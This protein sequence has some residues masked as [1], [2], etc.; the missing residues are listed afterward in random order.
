M[1][2]TDPGAPDPARMTTPGYGFQE[3]RSAPGERLPWSRVSELV[4]KARNYWVATARPDGRP[5]T[6]PVW[7]VWL[8]GAFYFE[9]SRESR[10]A[11]N[12]AANPEIAVHIENG[13][14]GVILEGTV[15]EVRDEAA[16]V[17][18]AAA[19][20]SKYDWKIEEYQ[21]RPISVTYALRPR[22]AFSFSEDLPETATRWLFRA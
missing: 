21:N 4:A 14:V 18:F 8:D 3:A 17:R 9:T 6:A 15:E 19:Y 22:V 10:K 13:D 1:A 2:S 16:I 12:L 7:G 5:H 11:R 20:N